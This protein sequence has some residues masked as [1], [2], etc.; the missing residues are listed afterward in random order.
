MEQYF[1]KNTTIHGLYIQSVAFGNG[2]INV[3]VSNSGGGIPWPSAQGRIARGLGSILIYDGTLYYRFVWKCAPTE[4]C[5][6][7]PGPWR[8]FTFEGTSTSLQVHWNQTRSG[9]AYAAPIT[10]DGLMT[11]PLSYA[12]K[13]NAQ[14]T[15]YLQDVDNTIVD[16][17]I[18][19]SPKQ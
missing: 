8:Y 12:W 1:S 5:N 17:M 19:H 2:H 9:I 15:V 3:S 13:P 16:K 14:Y 10:E 7:A 18:I 4:P 11:V 6:T